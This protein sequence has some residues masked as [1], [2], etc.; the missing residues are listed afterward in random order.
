MDSKFRKSEPEYNLIAAYL[1]RALQD[2]YDPNV[3]NNSQSWFFDDTLEPFSFVWCLQVLE[4]EYLAPKIRKMI[5]NTAQ[6]NVGCK[7]KSHK[8][9]RKKR[10]EDWYTPNENTPLKECNMCHKVLPETDFYMRNQLYRWGMCKDCHLE[11][12]RAR[13]KLAQIKRPSPFEKLQLRLQGQH[14]PL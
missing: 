1:N 6:F 12:M 2:V 4:M 10:K 13:K 3:S 11:Y 5:R 7:S 14:L 8:G 9:I